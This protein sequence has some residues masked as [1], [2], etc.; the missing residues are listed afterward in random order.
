M[1]VPLIVLGVALVMIWLENK[2]P[3]RRW[4]EVT[5][6]WRRAALLNGVQFALVLL[7]GLAWNEWLRE[8]R[9]WSAD[10]LGEGWGAL[11]G[12][13]TLT[14][15]YYW[16]HRWRHEV[17]LFWRLHQIHHSA[18]RIEVLTSFYKHPLEIFINCSITSATLYLLLGLG[19]RAAAGAVLLTGLGELFYHWNYRTP[20][21]V[22]YF[23]QRPESHCVHHEEGIHHYN[24]SDLPLWDMLFGTFKNPPAWEGR[25]GLGAEN[26]LRLLEMLA[27]A[28]VTAAAAAAAAADEFKHAGG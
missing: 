26:E 25:C 4:P 3:G 11:L 12:Y 13:L 9:P 10:W 27:G 7:T 8:N 2:R 21:W 15:I 5:G 23:F 19:P 17:A 16:W 22:G 1:I 14:F 20:P 18:Q 24:Y 6:W 28:D